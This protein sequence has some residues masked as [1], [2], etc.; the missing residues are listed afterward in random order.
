MNLYINSGEKLISKSSNRGA[1][2]YATIN[3]NALDGKS[4]SANLKLLKLITDYYAASG[5]AYKKC[6]LKNSAG[7]TL[8]TISCA[9]SRCTFKQ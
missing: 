6:V 5:Y 1:T 2:L 8:G 7:K 4:A 3:S 9:N